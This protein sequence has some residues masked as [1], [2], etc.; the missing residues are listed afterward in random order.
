MKIKYYSIKHLV[1]NMSK[2]NIEKERLLK[3]KKYIKGEI[4]FS[5]DLLKI[6][7][8]F[9]HYS[10]KAPGPTRKG[11]SNKNNRKIEYRIRN[12]YLL[13]ITDT[14]I[15]LVKKNSIFELT[16]Y[17]KTTTDTNIRTLETE[18][19]S[20]FYVVYKKNY[21]CSIMPNSSYKTHMKGKFD[22]NNYLD[23]HFIGIKTLYKK[24][25]FVNSIISLNKKLNKRNMPVILK[26]EECLNKK[27]KHFSFYK[28]IHAFNRYMR[29]NRKTFNARYYA[30]TYNFLTNIYDYLILKD[31]SV[32]LTLKKI[33]PFKT[34]MEILEFL[35]LNNIIQFNIEGMN[36][37]QILEMHNLINY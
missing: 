9:S 2:S 27:L 14:I 7:L 17:L 13:F 34:N 4:P 26:K 28:D 22:L 5:T 24:H 33:A 23:E 12:E 25:C 29:Q 30:V 21:L 3:I 18:V 6:N 16:V 10:S 15:P 35:N 32:T 36:E 19:F 20:C 8:K 11:Y 1:N 37:E 31:N